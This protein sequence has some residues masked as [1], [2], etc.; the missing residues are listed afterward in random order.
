MAELADLVVNKEPEEVLVLTKVVPV[1]LLGNAAVLPGGERQQQSDLTLH[2][3]AS[4]AT[5][6]FVP[7]LVTG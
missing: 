4:R 2:L 3:R 1:V 7:A 6:E 5:I